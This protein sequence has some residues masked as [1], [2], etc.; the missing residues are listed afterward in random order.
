MDYKD[1]RRTLKEIIEG[2]HNKPVNKNFNN[3]IVKWKLPKIEM[4]NKPMPMITLMREVQ[5]TSLINKQHNIVNDVGMDTNEHMVLEE[6]R[7][8]IEENYFTRTEIVMHTR[9]IRTTSEDEMVDHG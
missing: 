8:K 6:L 7:Y 5:L 3:S 1:C 9:V 4:Q 2:I